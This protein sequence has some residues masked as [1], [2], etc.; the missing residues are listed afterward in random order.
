[1]AEGEPAKR[2]GITMKDVV[3]FFG[4]P[5]AQFP[6][7]QLPQETIDSVIELK[8][9]M[10]QIGIDPAFTELRNL[11]AEIETTPLSSRF[12]YTRTIE[13]N[14][15]QYAGTRE[16]LHTLRGR[17]EQEFKRLQLVSD[18]QGVQ[19]DL[20]ALVGRLQEILTDWE[21]SKRD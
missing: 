20:L 7:E 13:E 5:A 19:T 2:D 11:M 21:V 3:R 4:D 8:K 10:E 14:M 17:T 1:M 9:R 16:V 18:V 15:D 12:S 6:L